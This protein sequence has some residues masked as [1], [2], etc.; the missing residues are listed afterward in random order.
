MHAVPFCLDRKAKRKE[1]EQK[2]LPSQ[3]MTTHLVRFESRREK[4]VIKPIYGAAGEGITF[5]TDPQTLREYALYTVSK[6]PHLFLRPNACS[7]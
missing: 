4:V 3:S 6:Q 2:L 1:L 5:V 7:L